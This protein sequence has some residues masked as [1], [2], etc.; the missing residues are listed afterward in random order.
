M[1]SR[2]AHADFVAEELTE[3]PLQRVFS[4]CHLLISWPV[5]SALAGMVAN[6]KVMMMAEN[7]ISFEVIFVEMQVS[8]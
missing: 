8:I 6:N 4:E 3:P 2:L 5:V 1:L 7:G